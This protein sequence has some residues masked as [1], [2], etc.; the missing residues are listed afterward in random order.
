MK[1]FNCS[2]TKT[3][4][5]TVQWKDKHWSANQWRI[6]VLKKEGACLHK[7]FKLTD[8]GLRFT[9]KK[10]KFVKKGRGARPRAPRLN[11][12]LPIKAVTPIYSFFVVASRR[13]DLSTRGMGPC[14]ILKLISVHIQD[15]I[16]M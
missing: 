1:N 5:T 13:R 8:F 15:T 9:L 11:P 3:L 6:Q 7:I 16:R 4:E 12:P 2:A 10:V 14:S